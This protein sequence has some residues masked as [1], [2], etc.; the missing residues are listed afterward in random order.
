MRVAQYTVA[1]NL[2]GFMAVAL[3]AGSLAD[4]LRSAGARLRMRPTAFVTCARSTI[5]HQQSVERPGHDRR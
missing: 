2:G 4:S 3:L 1:I 5:R